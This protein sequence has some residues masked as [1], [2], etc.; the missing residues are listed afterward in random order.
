MIRGPGAHGRHRK[1]E[2][3]GF[4]WPLQRSLGGILFLSVGTS[5]DGTEKMEPDLP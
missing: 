4:I 3:T 1:A 2:G 5:W